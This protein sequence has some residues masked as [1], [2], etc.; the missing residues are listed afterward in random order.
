MLEAEPQVVQVAINL[1]DATQLT[2]M[3]AP[4]HAVR[5]GPHTGRYL[6][7]ETVAAG[8]A[9]FD[10]ARL[11]RI[12]DPRTASL[13]EVLCIPAAAISDISR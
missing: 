13:D 4:E 2:H 12:D 7:T 10:T 9:L 3:S 1:S 8:P 5:R 11:G 6:I